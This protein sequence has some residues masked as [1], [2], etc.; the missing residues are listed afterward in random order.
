MTE[1]RAESYLAKITREA[2]NCDAIGKW[3][4]YAD[5]RAVLLRSLN[6]FTN[7]KYEYVVA[8]TDGDMVIGV[9]G[10]IDL[11]DFLDTPA[12]L[13]YLD[14]MARN[15][16]YKDFDDYV[17][18][19]EN[20]LASEFRDEAHGV[21]RKEDGSIDKENSSAYVF[22]L[23]SLAALIAEHL[24]NC[25]DGDYPFHMTPEEASVWILGLTG[26]SYDF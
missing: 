24:F 21:I 17:L 3:E 26:L 13:R 12:G 7:N 10:I 1:K 22:S 5:N 25:V 8:E 15:L 9:H 20:G 23:E 4:D 16:G 6:T 18:M 11:R 14:A 19:S 2:I